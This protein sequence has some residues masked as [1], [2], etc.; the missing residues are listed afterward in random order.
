MVVVFVEIGYQALQI[1]AIL[2]V[3]PQLYLEDT[4]SIKGLMYISQMRNIGR[5][6]WFANVD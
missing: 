2:V 6:C 3:K 1:C 5:Q 4:L